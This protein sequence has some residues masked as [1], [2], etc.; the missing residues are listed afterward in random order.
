MSEHTP[1]PWEAGRLYYP[2]NGQIGDCDITQDMG[3]VA[4]VYLPT[5]ERTGFLEGRANV[6]FL[7]RAVNSSDAMLSACQEVLLRARGL[8]DQPDK[9]SP[10]LRTQIEAAVEK[11][12]G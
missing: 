6:G 7:I 3:I 2:A 4:K 12:K 11:A 1:I 5:K 8:D 10:T 9:D